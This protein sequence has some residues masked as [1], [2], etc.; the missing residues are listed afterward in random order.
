VLRLTEEAYGAQISVLS[1]KK[2]EKSIYG[3]QAP[4]PTMTSFLLISLIALVVTGGVENG[5]NAMD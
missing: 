5:A 3:P 1:A 2:A 4:S